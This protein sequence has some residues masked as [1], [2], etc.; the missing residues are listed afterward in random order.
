M[1]EVQRHLRTE[2]VQCIVLDGL[3]S[4]E[5]VQGLMDEYDGESL[6]EGIMRNVSSEGHND[7]FWEGLVRK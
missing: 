7:Y 6:K 4:L 5:K 3:F 1:T 2:F